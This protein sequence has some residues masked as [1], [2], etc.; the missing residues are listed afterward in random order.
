MQA[1]DAVHL[2]RQAFIVGRD[3]CRAPLATDQLQE[4]GENRLGRRLLGYR[5]TNKQCPTN[6]EAA[7][8]NGK[9]GPAKEELA[10]AA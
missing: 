9:G 8:K 5:C 3:E 10:E 2:G 4:F 7:K 1:D 6:A